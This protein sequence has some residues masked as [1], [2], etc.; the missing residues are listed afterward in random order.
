MYGDRR[1]EIALVLVRF[2]ADLISTLL[3]IVRLFLSHPIPHPLLT[4]TVIMYL[5]RRTVARAIASPSTAFVAKPRSINTIAPPAFH[6]RKQFLAVPSFQ[7]RF[8]SDDAVNKTG[9][10]QAVAEASDNFAQTA[11]EAPVEENLTPAEES[12][13]APSTD[14]S[15]TV[16]IDALEQAAEGRKR[17]QRANTF[18]QADPNNTLYIGNLFY[19]VTTDQIQRVFSRFGEVK[20][21]KIAFDNRGL[22]RGF[23]YVTFENIEHAQAAVENLHMQIFEGRNM[24]VQFH[25]PKSSSSVSYAGG[26]A[27]ENP[28]SKTLFIGNM[29]Y[30][31]SDKDLNDMFRDI[32]NVMDVRVAIDRRTGQ[33]RG[34]AH[35]D[36]IDVASAARAKEILQ[37]KKIYGRQ[38]RLDFSKS[39]I[40][41][42]GHGQRSRSDE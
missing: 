15:A 18:I 4:T 29:S 27:I 26:K 13:Q 5:L 24:V 31:M 28:P 12:V 9:A 2:R 41:G 14:A 38:L 40:S 23:A 6:S 19:E 1:S 17:P 42:H 35:A 33:P 11:T 8:A 16:G 10:E 39:A 3:I 7:R 34:F 36:F 21:V 30:E 25:K 20:D 32:R 37:D 22:S